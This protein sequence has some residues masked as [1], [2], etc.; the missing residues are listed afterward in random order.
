MRTK[1]VWCIQAKDKK[2]CAVKGGKKPNE[3]VINAA[4]TCDMNI[5]L[6]WDIEKRVPNCAECRKRVRAAQGC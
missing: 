5:V 4:T 1:P 3:A 6:P 2:W